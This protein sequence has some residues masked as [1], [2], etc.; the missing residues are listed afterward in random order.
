MGL[1]NS[2]SNW[3]CSDCSGRLSTLDDIHGDFIPM[4]PTDQVIVDYEITEFERCDE[5]SA[6]SPTSYSNTGISSK[7]TLMSPVTPTHLRLLTPRTRV[8]SRNAS[9]TSVNIVD[10]IR[11]S[12][13]LRK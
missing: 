8:I 9:M 10:S 13:S 7:I 2:K 6:S 4:R 12:T 5:I 1:F 3:F 11:S